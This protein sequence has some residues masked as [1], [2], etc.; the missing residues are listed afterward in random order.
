MAVPTLEGCI[1]YLEGAGYTPDEDDVSS[2]LDTEVTAQRRRCRIPQVVPDD[3]TDPVDSYPSDLIEAV[4][5]RVAHTL[6][7]RPLPFGV[8]PTVTDGAVAISKVGGLDAE[9]ARLEAPF[10]RMGVG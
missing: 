8:S 9:V 5:R 4:Y 6:A 7:L 10:R 1:T 2:A 3:E